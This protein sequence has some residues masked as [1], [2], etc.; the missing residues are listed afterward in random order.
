M[1]Y[2]DVEKLLKEQ[3]WQVWKHINEDTLVEGLEVPTSPILL[4]E[5][6]DKIQ[7]MLPDFKVS[8]MK[9]KQ[10]VLIKKKHNEEG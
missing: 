7:E 2:N 9:N 4:S 8:P 6:A 5:T 10:Y 1:E 3:G